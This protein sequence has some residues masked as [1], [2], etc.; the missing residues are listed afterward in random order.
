MTKPIIQSVT[1]ATSGENLY[2]LYMNPKKHAAFT[3]GGK[4]VISSKRNSKFTAFDGMLTG[5]TILTLHGKLIIQS[6]RGAHW[7]DT[8]IDST[9]ILHFSQAGRRGKI[10]LIH[11]N[12]P[13]HDHAG[14]T[15]GW[16]TYYWTPLKE[17]LKK[18]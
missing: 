18:K 14:V 5:H 7:N 8:D 16:K 3:G 4:V 1:F 9:L 13:D 15:D 11:V 12:V 17:F 2:N 6:W 10:D